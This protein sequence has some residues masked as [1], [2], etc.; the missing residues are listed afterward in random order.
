MKLETWA[1]RD[2]IFELNSCLPVSSKWPNLAEVI[3]DTRQ[4]IPLRS[5][6]I[7]GPGIIIGWEDDYELWYYHHSICL[8]EESISTGTLYGFHGSSKESQHPRNL[9]PVFNIGSIPETNKFVNI[10]KAHGISADAGVRVM[11]KAKLRA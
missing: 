5:T 4:Y 11:E 10:L 6:A 8:P 3:A 1:M 7:S 9:V 2:F